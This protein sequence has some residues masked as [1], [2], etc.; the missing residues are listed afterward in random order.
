MSSAAMMDSI[1][2]I[3]AYVS[4]IRIALLQIAAARCA[5]CGNN[6]LKMGTS[7]AAGIFRTGITAAYVLCVGVSR[8]AH[9]QRQGRIAER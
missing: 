9:N 3:F 2:F 8:G 6:G 5:C 4:T 1:R 7:L